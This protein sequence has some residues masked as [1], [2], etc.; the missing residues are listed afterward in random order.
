M[1]EHYDEFAGLGGSLKGGGEAVEGLKVVVMGLRREVEGVV[2]AVRQREERMGLLVEERAEL[3]RE[4]EKGLR[5]VRW[6]GRLGALESRL[7]GKRVAGAVEGARGGAQAGVDVQGNGMNGESEAAN[8]LEDDDESIGIA[9][10][11][12]EDD[13]SLDDTPLTAALSRSK[14]RVH[15]YS[16]LKK[17]AKRIGEVH[18]LIAAQQG[19]MTSVRITIL[20]DLET[21]LKQVKDGNVGDGKA[22]LKVLGLFRLLDAEREAV[23][24]LGGGGT[25]AIS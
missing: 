14:R 24:L 17:T 3:R 4:L 16:A 15:E 5:L 13:D 7:M 12:S 18:P 11:S 23:R 1:N 2:G 21:V 10:S 8:E 25:S 19:R 6:E 20:L 9:T 22:L